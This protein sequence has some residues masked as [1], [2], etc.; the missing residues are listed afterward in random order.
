[1]P[2]CQRCHVRLKAPVQGVED[3]IQRHMNSP[4]MHDPFLC[5][6]LCDFN[7]SHSKRRCQ[8]QEQGGT[9][10]VAQEFVIVHLEVSYEIL[11]GPV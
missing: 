10:N 7:L 6:R 3:N 9:W 4:T 11:L 1:M 2:G 8:D 5:S